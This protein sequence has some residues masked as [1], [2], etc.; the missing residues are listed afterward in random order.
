MQRQEKLNN[1]LQT[2]FSQPIT[3]LAFA[4]ADADF[5]RYFRAHLADG[6]SVIVMDAPPEKMSIAPF[7]HVQKLFCAVHVPQVLASDETQG[8][9]A[10]EDLGNSTFLQA[11]LHENR[12]EVHRTLLL[13]AVDTL[14]T[15]Q[16]SSQAGRL[17]E[18]DIDLMRREMDLF[19]DWYA[20]KECN[21]PLNMKQQKNWREGQ[22][23]LLSRLQA[24]EKV[25]VHRDFIVRNL[26]LRSGNPGVLDFQDAVYGPISYDILSLTRDAFIEWEEEFVLDIVVR[27]W[28]KAR[29][30]GLPV[31]AQFD[32]FYRDYEW[33]GVQRHFKVIGIFARLHH[34]DGKSHY[35]PEI[36]RF[37]AY[38]RKTLRRYSELAI[39][40][41]LLDSVCG[42]AD[43]VHSAYTF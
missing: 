13:E 10:L 15:L 42:V 28:Q 30:L 1:W 2:V 32:D 25:F 24:Q 4:A 17:P 11:M 5:R 31:N 39:F 14:L 33:I 19:V 40:L 37:V 34:R 26:M 20:A 27:Y 23:I 36:A 6:S 21:N 29:A 35:L 43:D 18:Y 9:V 38:L 12:P 16:Q 3:Q 8:F 41:P 22:A 7:L